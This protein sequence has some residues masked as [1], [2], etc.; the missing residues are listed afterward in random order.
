[1]LKI[2]TVIGARPQIIKAAAISRVIRQHYAAEI[3]EIIVHT[4]QHYDE[5]MS[6]VFFKELSIPR[7]NYNLEIGSDSHAKQ[8]AAM[9]TGI[10]KI[11]LA[12][13][14]NCVLV[15]GDTNSTL[16]GAVAASKIHVPIVHIEAG[17]RSFNK[18]MP[19]E[20]NRILCDHVSTLLFAPTPIGYNNLIKE[21]FAVDNAAPYNADNPKI[22]HCGDVMFDNSL[23]FAAIAAQQSSIIQR[24]ELQSGEFILATIHRNNNTDEPQRLNALF[25]AIQEIAANEHS[26]V[27]LPLHPRTAKL[28]QANLD[29]ELYSLISQNPYILIV[30]PA[31]F[32]EMIELEKHCKLV[33]TDSGGV[34]KEAFF[35]QKPCIILRSETEWQE[36]V[37][38]G[39]A[40]IADADKEK[41]LNAYTHYSKNGPLTYPAFYGDGNTGRFICAEILKHLS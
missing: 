24:M 41:I 2:L 21:G 40:I 33:L 37:D 26:K 8:T 11:L 14:P 17:L 10:E 39:N 29:K 12:E 15:Y 31:S 36:L 22:Y 4:G 18:K 9:M 34:Q 5:N 20:I 38:N 16:A 35:F 1:M 6:E 3:A 28:L 32:L 7:P 30:P 13:K 23:H 27:I 19:E 25:G